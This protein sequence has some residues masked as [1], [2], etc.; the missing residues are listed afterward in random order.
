MGSQPMMARAIRVA[1]ALPAWPT[2]AG[3]L[4]AERARPEL[5][6]APRIGLAI[7]TGRGIFGAPFSGN[8]YDR[9]F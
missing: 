4:D 1:K 8:L 9:A 6:P 7:R 3:S 2:I 5:S